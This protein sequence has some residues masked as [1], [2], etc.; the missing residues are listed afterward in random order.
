MKYPEI[1]EDRR[2]MTAKSFSLA[3]KKRWKEC[4]ERK[5]EFLSAKW[6]SNHFDFSESPRYG[7]GATCLSSLFHI[8]RW[9][10]LSAAIL[11]VPT[12]PHCTSIALHFS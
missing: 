5:D 2:K 12:V 10:F 4:E 3:A 6:L 1:E 7:Y 9:I 8:S 11:K